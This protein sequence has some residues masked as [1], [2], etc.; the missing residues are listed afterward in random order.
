MQTLL[1]SRALIESGYNVEVCCYFEWDE[2][3]VEEFK[4]TG[5][6]VQLLKWN[7]TIR[8]I[9]FIRELAKIFQNKSPDIVH[10]QYMAPGLLSI[11][12]ARL[13][14]VPAILATVHQPGIPHTIKNHLLL[15]IGSMLTNHFICVSEAVEK[16]WFG[17]AC[18]FDLLN[19]KMINARRHFTLPN[20][21]DIEGID[22]A[23]AIRS[24]KIGKIAAQMEGK[25]VIGTVARLS[26][27]KGIDILLEA[28]ALMHKNYQQTQLLIV[29]D[30]SQIDELKTL[31][32]RLEI[33]EAITWTGLLSW[34]EAIG[35]LGLM[36]VVVVPSRF[37][38]FG[39]TAAEAMACGKAVV[40]SRVG[41]L[42]EIIKDDVNG[43]LV[44]PEDSSSF[45]HVMTTL[46][47]NK[48]R[49][50]EIGAMARRY[51]KETYSYQNFRERCRFVY[52]SLDAC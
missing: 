38:G 37:E 6:R 39:L 10:V 34:Q 48:E 36:D 31:A 14:Q 27:E 26:R 23:L 32:Q 50:Q 7:R 22:K 13:A 8:T 24:L 2:S 47:R 28:F 43:M 16:S 42:E 51:I 5:A 19:K 11:I 25:Q 15:R 21:I 12:A 33:S 45:Y 35:C 18:S 1:L 46:L 9:T 29:G 20:A 4:D 17:D 3:V 44:Q 41:G 30:G 52:E 40:A 49:R